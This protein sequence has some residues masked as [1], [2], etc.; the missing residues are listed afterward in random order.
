[1]ARV[2]IGFFCKDNAENISPFLYGRYDKAFY[3]SFEGEGPDS[4]NKEVIETLVNNKFGAQVTFLSAD[5]KTLGC[6]YR[7]LYD[8]TS[9]KDEYVID[10]TGG[11][12]LF[13]KFVK[14]SV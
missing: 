10:I 12:G 2:L 9:G 1:M 6:A 11:P 8:L 7:L 13:L 14:L 4:R 5:E 3:I